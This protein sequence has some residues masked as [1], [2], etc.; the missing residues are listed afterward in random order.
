MKRSRWNESEIEDM[1][2]ELPKVKDHRNKAEVMAGIYRKKKKK[3]SLQLLAGVASLCLMIVVASV[4][5]IGKGREVSQEKSDGSRKLSVSESKESA[6]YGAKS[7]E[8]SSGDI[9]ESQ[10]LTGKHAETE[11]KDEEMEIEPFSGVQEKTFAPAI[12]DDELKN[13]SAITLG[14]PDDQMNIVVPISIKQESSDESDQLNRMVTQM[15][16]IDE[17]RYGLSDYF[18]LDVTISEGIDKTTAH[19]EFKKDS[20]L[21]DEDDLFLSSMEETLSYNN[22]TKMTFA[23]DGKQGAMFSHAGFLK[24]LEIPEHKHRTYLLYQKNQ[25]SPRLLVP[26]TVQY[27]GFAEALQAGKRQSELKRVSPAIPK[28]LVWERIKSKGSH[29]TIQLAENMD[30]ENSERSLEALEAILFI[31]KDFGYETVK[32]EHAP[33]EKV[34]HL[35]LTRDI[36]VPRAPNQIK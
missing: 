33:I 23:T 24:Q 32:F 35:N 8:S 34:G 19:I 26:S 10:T 5:M 36:K 15:S 12:Y 18:P 29:V 16:Q 7:N 11:A 13:A 4:L 22:I 30:M 31:A 20:P 1:L 2:R 6:D 28:D 25:S 9:Q 17:E 3:R 21:L 14:I 27:H